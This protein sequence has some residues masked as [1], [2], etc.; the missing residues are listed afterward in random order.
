MNELIQIKLPPTGL[1]FFGS[2]PGMGLTRTTLKIA[3]YI[4]RSQGVVFISYQDYKEK[5]IHI[6]SQQGESPNV[7]LNIET[8]LKFYDHTLV[9]DFASIM[10]NTGSNTV[11]VDDLDSMLGENFDL[12]IQH[13]ERFLHELQILAE[14]KKVR[15]ILNVTVSK[16]VEYRGGDKRP[17]LRDFTWSRNISELA[18]QIYTVYRP[19]YY[20]ITVDENGE[21]TY[22]R[23]ELELIKDKDCKEVKY[24]LLNHNERIIP[25]SL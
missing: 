10:S 3:N 9:R 11:V 21:S 15:I 24:L 7:L 16:K 17:M 2:R 6:L 8:K 25:D 18:N 22:G 1:I 13:R 5:L 14:L 19:E 4:A 20:A 23:I 12:E